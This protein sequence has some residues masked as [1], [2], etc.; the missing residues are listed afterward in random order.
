M[1]TARNP[2]SLHGVASN[3][4]N[5]AKPVS[6][7]VT[8]S[9]SSQGNCIVR[10]EAPLYGSGPCEVTASN[11]STG[12]FT[13]VSNG[14]SGQIRWAGTLSSTAYQGTYSVTYP[15]FPQI[16]ETGSFKLIPNFVP[17]ILR[18]EDVLWSSE[19]DAKDGTKVY[20][21]ADRDMV[22]FLNSKHEYAGIR[23]LLDD[24]QEPFIRI[25]D[26]KDGSLYVDAK[27]NQRLL[28][29][30]T[31]GKD[32]YFCKP[33]GDVT[34]YYDRFMNATPWSS[35]IVQGSTIYLKDAGDGVDLYDSSFKPLNI[36]YA[37]ASSGKSYW[38]STD[39]TGLTEYFDDSFKSLH[40]LSTV[41]EGQ[42]YYAHVVGKKV[43]VYDSVMHPI[44]NKSHFWANLG[45]GLAVGLA[46]YG[47]AIQ[48]RAAANQQRTYSS[49]GGIYST[50]TQPI[51][52]TSY[53]NSAVSNGTNYSTT[54]LTI[55]D[56]D[57]STTTGSNGY[58]ASTTNQHIGNFGY[59][60]GSSSVGPISGSTQKLGDS[61][62]SNY[63]TAAGQWNGSSQRIGDFTYHTITSPSG[64]VHTGTTQKIGDFLYTTI[65]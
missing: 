16:P 55:G 11:D 56:T 3:T 47:Q 21:L 17:V 37:K 44:E 4:A 1:I 65:Q 61:T 22:Y 52:G 2:P 39:S 63:S 48:A 18:L 33:S 12:L 24:K 20:A 51:G 53:S 25:E 64:S 59:I 28:E 29:W 32:G 23:V 46:A 9:I 50:N 14:P 30:H 8:L 38:A 34:L 36:R 43:K 57:Y 42:T 45:K 27:T 60:S 54:T 10:V 6:A 19:F 13:I 49:P 58:Y 5:S 15:D 40:W 62:Y 7:M 26:H 35:V 41:R 31:A